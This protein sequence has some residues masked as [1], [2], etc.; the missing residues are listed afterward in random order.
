MTTAPLRVVVW[1]PGGL[2][3]ICIREIARMKEF[4]LV[5]VLCY[6]EEKHG[7]DAG[8]LAGIEPLGVTATTDVDEVLAIE[9]DC[10]LHV[11]RDHGDY[12]SV[13]EI[14]R[15]LLAGRNVITV[16][17]YHHLEHMDKT[18]A[19][20]GTAER[21]LAAA[22]KGGATFHATGIHPEFVCDR[23]SSALTG[24]CTDVQS[25]KV[26][27]N[28]D[29]SFISY[30]HASLLG[31]GNTPEYAAENSPSAVFGANY[32]LQNLHGLA[33]T[34]GVTLAKVGE[35]HEYAAVAVDLDLPNIFIKTGTVGRLT[36]RYH[37]YRSETEPQPF[38]TIEV[39]WMM[40]RSEHVLPAHADPD[41]TYTISI[42]GHPSVRAGIDL[43]KSLT[44]NEILMIEDDPNSDPVYYVTIATVL[45][46]VPS[47]VAAPP[48]ALRIPT[49]PLHWSADVRELVVSSA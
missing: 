31:F 13:A 18:T 41:D 24:I 40:G 32:C 9:S 23:I 20:P 35:E 34:L 45:L 22:A 1:G 42:E 44:T 30:E 37:G 25:I 15:I 33:D 48:G 7:K 2:G 38:V 21:I 26:D 43:R 14:E 39:N 11:T 3:S 10:I 28:A 5:G 16:H 47:V 19:P 6:G 27:E 49:P 29:V 8:E 17:P 12:S 4:Q 36:H 46:A